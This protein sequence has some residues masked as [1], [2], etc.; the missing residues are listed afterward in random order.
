[1]KKLRANQFLIPTAILLALASL[2]VKA[3]TTYLP[4]TLCPEIKENSPTPAAVNY[5][6]HLAPMEDYLEA[7]QL[8]S[9]LRN[10]YNP[11]LNFGI[12][13]NNPYFNIYRSSGLGKRGLRDLESH[14]RGTHHPEKLPSTIIY[15]NHYA[16]GDRSE[17]IVN[18]F[19]RQYK[20]WDN[21]PTYP[22]S[23]FAKEQE[24]NNQFPLSGKK[25]NFFHPAGSHE[26]N[27]YL[28]GKN[29]LHDLLV[30]KDFSGK[31]QDPLTKS[32]NI[33]SRGGRDAIYR[34]LEKILT[35]PGP[36]LFHCKGGIHR[37]GMMA[38]LVR[39]LQAGDW[40]KP[41]DQPMEKDGLALKIKAK[42]EGKTLGSISLRNPAEYEYYLHNSQNFRQE[43]LEV[44]REVSR[45]ARFACLQKKF[46][47]YL[48]IPDHSSSV[49][50]MAQGEFHQ[51]A[52]SAVAACRQEFQE[53]TEILTELNYLS[54]ALKDDSLKIRAIG[55]HLTA[56]KKGM[57]KK[58][59]R[60]Q[61]RLRETGEKFR[62]LEQKII[63]YEEKHKI[64]ER[65]G[66]FRK[67]FDGLKEKIFKRDG[68]LVPYW[69][70]T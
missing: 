61:A 5:L 42:R 1:M 53:E 43:N 65:S 21:R 7:H 31:S 35:G 50:S 12:L 19:I 29:P 55:L 18:Y 14:L 26:D 20:N 51:Y 63:Q 36:V 30:A 58:N 34:I 52:E 25:F 24:V 4:K 23:S 54:A 67:I 2:Q 41:W 62:Q 3:S 28:H 39:Y 11:D 45:D 27:V 32:L 49:P 47:P 22:Y 40:I 8:L 9:S 33:Y 48:N 37:T 6:P 38:L 10:S 57:G 68:K 16:Y 60:H 64:A 15:M 44:A 66:K 46:G 69:L 70:G 13:V 56:I 59:T 17:K